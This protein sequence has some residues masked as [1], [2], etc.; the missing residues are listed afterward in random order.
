MS[1]ALQLL[2]SGPLTRPLFGLISDAHFF[3]VGVRRSWAQPLSG[4]TTGEAP[5][6]S[7]PPRLR[8]TISLRPPSAH[9]RMHTE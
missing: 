4:A 9:E 5:R 2:P 3:V 6:I 1:L 8:S 7:E